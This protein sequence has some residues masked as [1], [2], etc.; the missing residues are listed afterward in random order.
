MQRRWR[1]IHFTHSLPGVRIAVWKYGGNF[2]QPFL[3][4]FTV[5][6]F[7]SLSGESLIMGWVA[8]MNPVRWL[9]PSQCRNWVK[10]ATAAPGFKFWGVFVKI[11]SVVLREIRMPLVQP[12]ETSFGRTVERAHSAGGSAK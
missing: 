11:D 9:A 1:V 5:L 7:Q 3:L 8:G 10:F 4:V 6:R 2:L 12:F